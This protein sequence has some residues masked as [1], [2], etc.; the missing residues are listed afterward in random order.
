MTAFYLC[1][2]SDPKYQALFERA[3]PADDDRFTVKNVTR[4]LA[5]FERSIISARSPYDRYHYGRD[6]NAVSDSAK[7]GEILF[8]NPAPF[9]AFAATEDSTSAMRR[10]P[11]AMQARE[12]E[13]HNTGLYDIAGDLSYPAPNVGIYEHTKDRRGRWKVQG[14]HIT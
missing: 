8:F 4:A 7:R 13:F 12:I 5:S 6:D 2:E 3:F 14:S 11:R 9:P 1:C 10:F